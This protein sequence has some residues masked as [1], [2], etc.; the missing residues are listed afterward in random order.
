MEIPNTMINDAIKQSAGYKY[1]KT[2]KAKIKKA[3]APEEPKEQHVFL[4]RSGQGKG[5]I[6]S[7]DQE[8]NV[9]IA[10]NKNVMPRKTRSPTMADIVQEPVA[11]L[12]GPVVED[13]SVRSL[14]DLRKGS[15]TSRLETWKHAKQEIGCEG[16][17]ATH[18]KYYEFKYI[19][20]NDNKATRDSSC[21]DIDEEKYE[22]TNDSDDSDMDL[23]A[24][25]P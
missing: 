20:T 24:D 17:S 11:K 3:K 23:S 14:L 13:P 22:G 16:S 1:Y 2:K 15:K 9:P 6:R 8:A 10:F 18:K 7:G 5:Y 21:L 19:S 12:K 25:K 4:V